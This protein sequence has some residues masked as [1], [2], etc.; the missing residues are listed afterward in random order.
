VKLSGTATASLQLVREV[1][2]L[3]VGRPL[4]DIALVCYKATA[5]RG[6]S[7]HADSAGAAA[8]EQV[9]PALQQPSS[10]NGVVGATPSSQPAVAAG[11]DVAAPTPTQ[12]V[13]HRWGGLLSVLDLERGTEVRVT[14]LETGFIIRQ[15]L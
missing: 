12:C 8:G 5:N 15:A 6:I 9:L 1:S 13:L 2:V 10:R 4:V 11:A 14:F 3:E 7:S